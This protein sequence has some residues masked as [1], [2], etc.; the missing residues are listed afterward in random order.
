[1]WCPDGYVTFNEIQRELR[2]L[3]RTEAALAKIS[4]QEQRLSLYLE[5][6]PYYEHAE[7]IIRRECI[8][9][10][11]STCAT[12][13][14]FSP[15]G[16]C[17]RVDARIASYREIPNLGWQ[18]TFI[19]KQTGIIS[20]SQIERCILEVN[21]YLPQMR[22]K[23]DEYDAISETD[24][25]TYYEL[26]RVEDDYDFW[27]IFEKFEG[28]SIGCRIEDSFL[29]PEDFMSLDASTIIFS[30]PKIN[31]S[32]SQ[33]RKFDMK[34]EIILAFDSGAIRSKHSLW[35]EVFAGETREAFRAAWSEA[36]KERPELSKRGPK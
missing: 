36:A 3:L 27:K 9:E 15:N 24:D 25:S 35:K 28:W 20:K 26:C 17:L 16:V 29:H 21:R 2:S 6:H 8:N 5:E 22:A 32:T 30:E 13:S 12:L 18:F 7:Q 23:I 10:V 4:E 31:Q 19:E 14:A 33:I 34:S 1:M 11:F